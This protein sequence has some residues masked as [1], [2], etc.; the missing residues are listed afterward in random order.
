[1]IQNNSKDLSF[2]GVVKNVEVNQKPHES[3]TT[4]PFL[5]STTIYKTSNNFLTIQILKH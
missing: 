5:C 2:H 1:M 4:I 3:E